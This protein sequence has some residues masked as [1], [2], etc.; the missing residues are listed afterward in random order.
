MTTRVLDASVVLAYLGNEPGADDAEKLLEEHRRGDVPASVAP[1]FPLEVMNVLLRSWR[2]SPDEA[3]LRVRW[4]G[5][6]GLGSSEPEQDRV[7][8]WTAAGLT[9][10]DAS[11][12]ALAEQLGC[13]LVTADREIVELA[14]GIARPLAA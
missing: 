4:L 14:P 13:E 11:Y 5:A 10:Y 6:L 7:F 12:V 3:E 8:G 1:T 9:A 2:L